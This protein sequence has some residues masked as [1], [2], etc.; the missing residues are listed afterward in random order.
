MTE[1]LECVNLASRDYEN[2]ECFIITS[3]LQKKGK[4]FR[5]DFDLGYNFYTSP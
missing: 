2:V 1:N 4:E 5:C 3:W